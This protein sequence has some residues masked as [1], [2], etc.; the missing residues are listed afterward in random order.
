MEFAVLDTPGGRNCAH[1]QT[2]RFLLGFWAERRVCRFSP[3]VMNWNGTNL[4]WIPKPPSA[5]SDL[6]YRLKELIFSTQP[7]CTASIVI[8]EEFQIVPLCA[9]PAQ[10]GLEK[11][12]DHPR[13]R[14]DRRSGNVIRDFYDPQ[15]G[16]KAA[17]GGRVG[18]FRKIGRGLRPFRTMPR[19]GIWCER[20]IMTV[21][22]T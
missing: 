4:P 7:S 12:P 19:I 8:H 10:G 18:R 3:P 2:G 5:C 21:M 9:R 6:R 22:A 16:N 20:S 13:C 1:W 17:Q 14:F 11:P 15:S